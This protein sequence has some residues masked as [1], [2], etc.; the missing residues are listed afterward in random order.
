MLFKAETGNHYS[1]E[2]QGRQGRG[3][4]ALIDWRRPVSMTAAI[5]DR[6]N[7]DTILNFWME[8]GLMERVVGGVRM[9]DGE[10]DFG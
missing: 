3:V 5:D 8:R 2:K 4:A 7:V 1:D 9:K 6:R 10:G